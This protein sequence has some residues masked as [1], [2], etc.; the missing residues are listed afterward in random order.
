MRNPDP[1]KEGVVYLTTTEREFSRQTACDILENTL[2]RPVGK[3]LHYLDANLNQLI[4]LRDLHCIHTPQVYQGVMHVDKLDQVSLRLPEAEIIHPGEQERLT[5]LITRQTQRQRKI[6][7]ARQGLGKVLDRMLPDKSDRPNL[8]APPMGSGQL[9]NRRQTDRLTLH[10]DQLLNRPAV[11]MFCG[12]ETTAWWYLD[13]ATGK[14]K[15]RDCLAKG[16]S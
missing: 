6:D 3:S 5:R 15:C 2:N 10:P 14:C 7:T 16:I 1:N 12:I 9:L 8:T 13:R 11:C 4:T